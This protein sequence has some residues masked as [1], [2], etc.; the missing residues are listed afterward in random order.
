MRTI[1]LIAALVLFLIAGLSAAGWLVNDANWNALVGF[2]LASYI[3][4][5]LVPARY[6]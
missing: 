6:A 1:L 4:S 5:L 3:G 2:G